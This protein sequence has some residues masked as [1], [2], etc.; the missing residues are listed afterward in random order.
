MLY[1]YNIL[2]SLILI[3]ICTKENNIAVYLLSFLCNSCLKKATWFISV[4]VSLLLKPHNKM[5]V[6]I[7]THF[8][9]LSNQKTSPLI[10]LL[11]ISELPRRAFK[12]HQL[13]TKSGFL[14]RKLALFVYFMNERDGN[15]WQ[16]FNLNSLAPN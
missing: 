2:Y 13:E 5:L 8:K 11:Y 14:P 12:Q 15:I 1:L 16:S 9:F 6:V 7:F 3:K 4:I 10:D